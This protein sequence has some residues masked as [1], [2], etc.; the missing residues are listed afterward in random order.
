MASGPTAG[1]PS[2]NSLPIGSVDAIGIA[3]TPGGTPILE[4]F[5]QPATDTGL[6]WKASIAGAPP[7]WVFVAAPSCADIDTDFGTCAQ[8]DSAVGSCRALDTWGYN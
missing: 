1:A 6:F 8:V 2:G 4:T 7:D 3:L 5:V